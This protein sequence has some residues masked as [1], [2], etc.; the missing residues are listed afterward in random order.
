MQLRLEIRLDDRV[1]ELR[2]LAQQE[3]VEFVARVLAVELAL[4]LA[5]Q[6]RPT[7]HEGELGKIRIVAQCREQPIDIAQRAV[8]LGL[9]RGDVCNLRRAASLHKLD[10]LLLRHML[11]GV[12]PVAQL[13]RPRLQRRLLECQRAVDGMRTIDEHH[14][15]ML[16]LA[17]VRAPDGDLAIRVRLEVG[18]HRRRK[19]QKVEIGAI[20]RHRFG[21]E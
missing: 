3:Q 11:L 20:G 1:E 14:V 16:P 5:G 21:R 19:R 12:E 4:L 8:D 13:A 9:G 6:L 15:H 18:Q 10:A 7:Q 17:E 2:V